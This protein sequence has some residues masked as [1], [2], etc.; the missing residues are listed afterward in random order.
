MRGFFKL[1]TIENEVRYGMEFSLE[2]VQQLC[3]ATFPLH[4][5]STGSSRPFSARAARPFSAR[6]RA[7]KNGS[8]A[9]SSWSKLSRFTSEREVGGFKGAGRLV[10]GRIQHAFPGRS[11]GSLR[12]RYSTK[13]KDRK[14]FR[15]CVGEV[16]MLLETVDCQMLVGCQVVDR[17]PR[18]RTM[19]REL[20]T[21]C[22]RHTHRL[23][24]EL[25][26]SGAAKRFI[27][28]GIRCRGVSMIPYYRS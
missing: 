14:A 9:S 26:S 11:T 8:G 22:T 28:C 6:A 4:T 25:E 23:E 20:G 1:I 17:K 10:V 24:R 27:D 15:H 7:K 2:D 19:E 3:A 13:L 21:G 16:E 18:T 12:V 5:S